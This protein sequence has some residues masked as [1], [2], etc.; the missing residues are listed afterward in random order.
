MTRFLPLILGV[1]V[2]GVVIAVLASSG[3]DAKDNASIGLLNGNA[4]G[5]GD[6]SAASGNSRTG[7]NG[8]GSGRNGDRS[9]SGNTTADNAT[10]NSSTSNATSSNSNQTSGTGAA[11]NTQGASSSD[12]NSRTPKSTEKKPS[13]GK[14]GKPQLPIAEKAVVAAVVAG[15][16]QTGMEGQVVRQADLLAQRTPDFRSDAGIRT[17]NSREVKGRVFERRSDSLV[18]LAGVLVT[19]DRQTARAFTDGEGRF[20]LQAR[21]RDRDAAPRAAPNTDPSDDIVSLVFSADGYVLEGESSSEQPGLVIPMQ[22]H[23]TAAML[24][25]EDGVS[26]VMQWKGADTVDVQIT[27]SAGNLQQLR[28]SVEAWA[29]STAE[30]DNAFYASAIPDAQGR[31]SFSV[32]ARASAYVIRGCGPGSFGSATTTRVHYSTESKAYLLEIKPTDMVEVRGVV[33][34]ARTGQPLR[35]VRLTSPDTNGGVTYT[36]EDGSFHLWAPSDAR[37]Q[38]LYL[39]HPGYMQV[40]NPLKSEHAVQRDYFKR[41]EG[42]SAESVTGPWQ[43]TMRPKVNILASLQDETRG[44]FRDVMTARADVGDESYLVYLT[45]DASGYASLNTSFFPW[46]ARS[47]KFSANDYAGTPRN[48]TVQIPEHLWDGDLKAQYQMSLVATGQ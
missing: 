5:S 19:D 20:T 11:A 17:V 40:H 27:G 10:G 18:P 44:G 30:A 43:I 3:G 33:R 34:D 36:G 31:C 4:E 28:V 23:F 26:V 25:S 47:L 9:R 37:H 48:F 1:V 38:Q 21:F 41:Q 29:P 42:A 45:K 46:G 39:E 7:P 24:D 32:P 16:V 35:S 13:I 14:D 22:Q 6:G 8:A 2:I 15:A 12:T